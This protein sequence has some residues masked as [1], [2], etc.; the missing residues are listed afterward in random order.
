MENKAY[1]VAFEIAGPSALFARPDTG[2]APV[3]YPVP[4]RS[5]LIGMLEAV[6]R[7]KSVYLKPHRVEICAPLVFHRYMTNYGGPLKGKSKNQQIAAMVLTNVCYKVYARAEE[8][9]PAPGKNNH[10]HALQEIFLRRLQ[11]GQFYTTPYLG[12]SE[13]TPTYFGIPRTTTQ[14]LEDMNL[15]IPS[16]LLS[17]FEAPGNSHVTPVFRQDVTVTKGVLLYDE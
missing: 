10:R 15:I 6:V 12:W 17:V 4:T 16:M 2:S 11:K 5:A 7:M 14:P 13:F 9:T 3:S 1:E 8:V